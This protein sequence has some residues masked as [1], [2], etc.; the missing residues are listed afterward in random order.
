[1]PA[2]VMKTYEE[3]EVQFHSFLTSDRGTVSGEIHRLAALRPG[4]GTPVY[5]LSMSWVGPR[6]DLDPLDPET[7]K[8]FLS[9][10]ARNLVIISTELCWSAT[11]RSGTTINEYYRFDPV[12]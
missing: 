5:P 10:P 8:Q 12:R 1:M 2:D 4:T 9:P 3:L 6:A 11:S 7:P